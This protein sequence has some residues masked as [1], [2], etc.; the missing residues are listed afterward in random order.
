METTLLEQES[1][2]SDGVQRKPAADED[3][4]ATHSEITDHDQYNIPGTITLQKRCT[5]T[6]GVATGLMVMYCWFDD[7]I[8]RLI[9]VL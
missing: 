4:T 7:N 3:A 2:E 1:H 9:Y 6:S 5:D 8:R